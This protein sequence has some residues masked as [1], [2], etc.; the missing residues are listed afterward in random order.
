MKNY[1]TCDLIPCFNLNK[2]DRCANCVLARA[3]K[4]LPNGIE[5]NLMA[6][7]TQVLD[8]AA[9]AYGEQIMV[10]QGFRCPN[11]FNRLNLP[12]QNAYV[13]GE[14]IDI[15]AGS[16][17]DNSKLADI[18]AKQAKFDQ[19]VIHPDHLH[20]TY[21]RAGGNRHEVIRKM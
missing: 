20:I 5:T 4:S 9:E 11:Y 21:H 15:T 10:L 14:A 2:A 13:T 16:L 7:V 3:V 19:M 6:L 12:R 8:P 1:N 18:I 17:A